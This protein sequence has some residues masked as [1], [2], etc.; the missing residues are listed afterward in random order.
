MEDK[1]VLPDFSE[2]F[3]TTEDACFVDWE[4][5][6]GLAAKVDTELRD[7]FLTDVEWEWLKKMAEVWGLERKPF[8]TD[9]LL[10]LGGLAEEKYDRIAKRFEGAVMQ[11]CSYFGYPGTSFSSKEGGKLSVLIFSDAVSF[12]HYASFFLESDEAPP[13][14]GCRVI[15][16]CGQLH[17]AIYADDED[18]LF[19]GFVREFTRMFLWQFECPRWMEI[20]V[21]IR[22]HMMAQRAEGEELTREAFNEHRAHWNKSTLADFSSECFGETTTK[23]FEISYHLA[24]ILWLKIE[25]VLEATPI[26]F[27]NLLSQVSREDGGEAALRVVFDVGIEDLYRSFLGDVL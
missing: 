19:T 22:M 11:V 3:R 21:L 2:F 25:N 9:N 10:I 27:Q 20:G 14:E 4:G 12:T 23:D 8:E 7:E 26:D 15:N 1:K 5:I 16:A 18:E 13:L 24:G 6:G 17:L